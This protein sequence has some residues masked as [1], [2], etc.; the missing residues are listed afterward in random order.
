MFQSQN[1]HPDNTKNTVC[2]LSIIGSVLYSF[3]CVVMSS[4]ASVCMRTDGANAVFTMLVPFFWIASSYFAVALLI[5][6]K[7]A[8]LGAGALGAM[9]LSIIFTSSPAL[10]ALSLAPFAAA[11]AVHVFTQ[12]KYM[13]QSGI[14]LTAALCHALFLIA[15]ICILLYQKYGSVSME[16]FYRALDS[17]SNIAMYLPNIIA[18]IYSDYIADPKVAQT[19]TEEMLASYMEALDQYKASVAELRQELPKLLI[20]S[21]PSTFLCICAIG[22]FITTLGAKKHRKMVGLEDTIGAYGITPISGIVYLII[23]LAHIFIDPYSAVGITLSAIGAAL[24]LGLAL[25]GLIFMIKVIKRTERRGLF[26]S[27]FIIA[28]V[29]FTTPMISMLSFVGAYHTVSLLILEKLNSKRDG[30]GN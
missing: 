16:S 18:D 29:I 3:L 17:F 12:K 1:N 24:G 15:L 28:A 30:D 7:Y 22:G 13:T 27:L 23:T 14:I 9:L 8:V 10:S 25:E 4:A 11:G 19:L 2:D 6:K 20:S 5:H 21:I 26:T